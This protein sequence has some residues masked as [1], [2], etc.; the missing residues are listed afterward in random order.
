MNS[1]PVSLTFPLAIL[2]ILLNIVKH[3]A[4]VYEPNLLC[5][6][7]SCVLGLYIQVLLIE[8]IIL[9]IPYN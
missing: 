2:Q 8:N 7:F 3:L 6:I 9:H 5:P 4:Y 1:D